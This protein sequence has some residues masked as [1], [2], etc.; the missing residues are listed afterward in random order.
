MLPP[1]KAPVLG[2]HFNSAEKDVTNATSWADWFPSSESVRLPSLSALTLP[3]RNTR[4]IHFG[5]WTFQGRRKTHRCL[6]SSSRTRIWITDAGISSV[7][8]FTHPGWACWDLLTSL[9]KAA[10]DI[11]WQMPTCFLTKTP[12]LLDRNFLV[13]TLAT[14]FDLVTDENFS[15]R[16]PAA[17]PRARGTRGQGCA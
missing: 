3:K 1:C 6:W 12:A 11:L 9:Q 5:P 13:A 4:K 10:T 16:C 8:P 7:S 15:P 17:Q 2:T 14:E